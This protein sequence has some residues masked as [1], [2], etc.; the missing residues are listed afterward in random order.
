MK[1]RRRA[2]QFT[3]VPRDVTLQP[4]DEHEI[5]AEVTGV[6]KPNVYV[7]DE[8]GRVVGEGEIVEVDEETVRFSLDLSDVKVRFVLDFV[9]VPFLTYSFYS[10]YK[11]EQVH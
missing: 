8:D 3:Q 4:G 11:P 1:L 6:P 9:N 5:V 2:P 7:T 10:T